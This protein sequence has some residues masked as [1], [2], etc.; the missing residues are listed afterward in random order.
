MCRWTFRPANDE[1]LDQQRLRHGRELIKMFVNAGADVN[2]LDSKGRSALSMALQANDTET[3]RLLL[4]AGALLPSPNA[5]LPEACLRLVNVARQAETVLVPSSSSAGASSSPS[6]GARRSS[7]ATGF[8][9]ASPTYASLRAQECVLQ[10]L[11]KI[12][13]NGRRCLLQGY[14]DAERVAV[15]LIEPEAS[16]NPG[17]VITVN[18]DKLFIRCHAGECERALVHSGTLKCPQCLAVAYCC[19]SCRKEDAAVHAEACN[20]LELPVVVQEADMRRHMLGKMLVWA[21]T[22]GDVDMLERELQRV[23][24]RDS[25]IDM[26]GDQNGNILNLLHLACS[27]GHANLVAALARHGADV[28][29]LRDSDCATPLVVATEHQ[30]IG[31]IDALAS[32]GADMNRLTLKGFSP[33]V[34][35]VHKDKLEAVKAL[36]RNGAQVDSK[37]CRMAVDEDRLDC[38]RVLLEANGSFLAEALRHAERF[39]F[40]CPKVLAALRKEVEK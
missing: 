28:N 25:N 27:C 21:C 8:F 26:L 38:L 13:F 24:M 39:S 9:V 12:E 34:F 4:A 32:H 16:A 7:L 10:E 22:M 31:C 6:A 20:A 35:A 15:Q 40:R 5:D 14:A 11:G 33:L 23:G 3:V 1:K 19:E 30:H 29:R 2:L 18:F 37:A 17:A 36:V